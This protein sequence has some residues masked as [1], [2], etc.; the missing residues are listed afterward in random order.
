MLNGD[1]YAIL[2]LMNR[3][4]V[5]KSRRFTPLWASRFNGNIHASKAGFT[6]VEVIIVLAVSSV[7]LV[8]ALS[9]VGGQ[10]KKAEFTQALSDIQSQI[11]GVM[12][13]VATGY[14][15]NPGNFQCTTTGDIAK[16][17]AAGADF[18]MLGNML[19]GFDE[20]LSEKQIKDSMGYNLEKDNILYNKIPF[21]GNSSKRIKDKHY[22]N[23]QSIEGKE[24][25]IDLKGPVIEFIKEM[26]NS[27]QSTCS[28]VGCHDLLYLTNYITFVRVNNT[29][30]KIFE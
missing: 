13:N 17:F 12:N 19:S 25:L 3:G 2:T 22:D 11:D 27:L 30:N 20:G 6:I 28:Y 4:L 9:L 23:N 5:R 10:Q 14:Y 24:V 8:S 18:V 29:H 16:A 26:K 7:L 21:Y 1:A 15:A